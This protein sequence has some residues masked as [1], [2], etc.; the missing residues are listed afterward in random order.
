MINLLITICARG[1][2]KGL[3]GKNIKKLNG[4]PLI[5]YSIK[6]ALRFHDLYSENNIDISLSTDCEE[7]KSIA[8]DCGLE[9]KYTRPKYLANDTVGK[10][11]VLD[12]ILK[13][14]ESRN[15]KKYDFI[16]DLDVSSPLR[17]IED[18]QK[19]FEIIKTNNSALNIFSVSKAHKNPYFNVV[20]FKEDGFCKL[21]KLND[22]KSR[23]LAPIV[24]DMN[25][26]FYIYRKTFFD[27]NLKSAITNRSL[28]FLMNHACFDI[29]EPIDFD[30]MEFLLISNKL[31]FEL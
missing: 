27:Q 15:N 10:I 11:E 4:R 1:G 13:Y 26:S 8:K 14:Q 24:F 16:L 22:S 29:D 3:P 2:S 9:S 12:H 28:M 30:I 25:A 7:I 31:D 6:H 20:E 5:D 17:T 18:L 23:Q 19:A 21:V